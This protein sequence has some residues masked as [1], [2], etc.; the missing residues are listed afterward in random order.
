MASWR[1]Y[2][3]DINSTLGDTNSTPGDMN[4][5][6]GDINST[7]GDINSNLRDVNST[8][9]DSTTFNM[10]VEK[11]VSLWSFSARRQHDVT[12]GGCHHIYPQ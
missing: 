6:L 11:T 1:V 5:A 12:Q 7:L 4:S 10:I 3:D 9:G 8:V 2:V